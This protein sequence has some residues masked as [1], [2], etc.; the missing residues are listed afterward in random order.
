MGAESIWKPNRRPSCLVYV[1]AILTWLLARGIGACSHVAVVLAVCFTLPLSAQ[2]DVVIRSCP[3]FKRSQTQEKLFVDALKLG[4]TSEAIIAL[5]GVKNVNICVPGIPGSSFLEEAIFL[6]NPEVVSA[7][8]ERGARVTPYSTYVAVS[9]NHAHEDQSL[10]I[11]DLLYARGAEVHDPS[12]RLA[13]AAARQANAKIIRW[14]AEHG[15]DVDTATLLESTPLIMAIIRGDV[16]TVN[17][18]LDLGANI[19]GRNLDGSSPGGYSPLFEAIALGKEQ[20]VALL[21]SRG[22]DVNQPS[23]V[24]VV[25]PPR[26]EW[27]TPLSQVLSKNGAV[28]YRPDTPYSEAIANM[29]RAA[30]GHE[31]P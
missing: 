22:A 9:G 14:L 8:L 17:T 15:A 27:C 28:S 29:L 26:T 24:C 3:D 18:L 16:E 25:S 21:L 19:R 1:R 13:S 31:G 23:Q 4:A 7:L 12:D 11:L 20:I 2:A 10:E 30:G 6:Q 5:R